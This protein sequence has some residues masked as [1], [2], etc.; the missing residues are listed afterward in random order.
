MC[1]KNKICFNFLIK[2]YFSEKRVGEF[3]LATNGNQPYCCNSQYTSAGLF[4]PAK[5]YCK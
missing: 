5:T 4:T 3:I 2:G 1:V